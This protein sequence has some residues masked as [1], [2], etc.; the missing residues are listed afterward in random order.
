MYRRQLFTFVAASLYSVSAWSAGK[1][2]ELVVPFPPGGGGDLLARSFA[3]KFGEALSDTLFVL[4]KPG[5]GGNIGIRTVAIEKQKN[6]AV[7]Y[8]TNGIFCVNPLL[9]Q[10]MGFDP[11]NDLKLIGKFSQIGLVAVLNPTAIPGVTD[12]PSLIQYAKAHP[13]EV[14]FASAGI[15]TTSH[16]AGELFEKRAGIQLTHIPHK[17]GAAAIVEVL[18]GRVPFMI[19]V[20]PNVLTHIK[21]GNLKPLAVSTAQRNTHLPNV[22][23]MKEAGIDNY[24]LF[25]WDGLVA[26]KDTSQEELNRYISAFEKAVNAPEVKTRLEKLGAELNPLYGEAFVRFI[27]EEKKK[28]APLVK[29]IND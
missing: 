2:I 5:A 24:E 19:E 10:N 21:V 3:D 27:E 6:P 23:T 26:P 16:A 29:P 28:W 8:V 13:G 1:E 4:N 9:Y 18:A 15:G 17:G 7:G 11:N 22:P 20:I 25:A 12:L 14:N